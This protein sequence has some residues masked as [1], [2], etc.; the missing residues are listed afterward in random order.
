MA[1]ISFG[2]TGLLAEP[3]GL[4]PRCA[5]PMV[6]VAVS[7]N[8]SAVLGKELHVD[9]VRRALHDPIPTL[10][11]AASGHTLVGRCQARK[12]CHGGD[13]R[14]FW[15]L[16]YS[17]CSLLTAPVSSTNGYN[18]SRQILIRIKR[19]GMHCLSPWRPCRPRRTLV[20][21][22]VQWVDHIPVAADV[23]APILVWLALRAIRVCCKSVTATRHPIHSSWQLLNSA[24]L[25]CWSASLLRRSSA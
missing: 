15:S 4:V 20:P 1:Q 7:M 13:S 6:I 18:E 14:R 10:G 5:R 11:G 23:S 19:A 8:C 21:L 9:A 25:A 16:S 12:R 24:S 3:L 2:F 17:L 22:R